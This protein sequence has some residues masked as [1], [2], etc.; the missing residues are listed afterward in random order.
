[1]P[2]LYDAKTAFWYMTARGKTIANKKYGAKKEWNKI[3]FVDAK[4]RIVE[5]RQFKIF[6]VWFHRSRRISSAEFYMRYG[7]DET[8]CWIV[9]GL[10]E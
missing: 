5:R 6:G 1:M 10:F 7:N 2:T 8:L 4:G 3:W 9:Y